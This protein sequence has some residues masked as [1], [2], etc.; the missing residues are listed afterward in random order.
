MSGCEAAVHNEWTDGRTSV[1]VEAAAF[2]MM[3]A[4]AGP[5]NS[6]H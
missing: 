5:H 6:D 1:A 3:N 2:N 4:S